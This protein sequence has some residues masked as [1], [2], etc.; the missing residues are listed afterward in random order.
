MP[1]WSNY[2]KQTIKSIVTKEW[3]NVLIK[4]HWR[5]HM[6]GLWMVVTGHRP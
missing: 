1:S 2:A 3:Y 5:S 6:V 4:T